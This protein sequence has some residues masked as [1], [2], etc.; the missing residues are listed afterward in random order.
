MRLYYDLHIHSCLSPCGD[1]DMTP[2][3]IVNMA[4]LADLNLIALT[5]HNTCRNCPAILRAAQGSGLTVL[6][7]MELCSAEEAH[8]VCLFP[9]LAAAQAFDAAVYPTLPPIPNRPEVFGEQLILDHEDNITGRL[10]PLLVTASSLSVDDI[11]ALA[12][13]FGGTAFPAHIDRPSYSVTAALGDV[14]PVGFSAAEITATG[15]VDALCAQ[16]PLIR[17]LPLLQSSDAHYLHQ[18]AE[19]GP[20][21]E[22]PDDRPETVIAALDGRLAM[23]CG[24]G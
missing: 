10:E 19:A 23:R 3:N 12:R 9:D 21:L 6:P 22:L 17:G 11:P 8:I 13:R 20:W 2:N 14:P 1:S 16:Y 15:D 5:D 4:R 24:R 18:I 7:G